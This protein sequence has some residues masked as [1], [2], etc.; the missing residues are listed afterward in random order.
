MAGDDYSI[1]VPDATDT[2]PVLSG[3]PSHVRF[4]LNIDPRPRWLL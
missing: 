2:V 4:R 1:A 3:A